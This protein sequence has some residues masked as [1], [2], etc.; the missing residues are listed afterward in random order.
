MTALLRI[1]NLQ[2]ELTE[3]LNKCHTY[4]RAS[5]SNMGLAKMLTQIQMEMSEIKIEIYKGNVK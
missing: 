1:E 2:K 3:A 5:T 4:P